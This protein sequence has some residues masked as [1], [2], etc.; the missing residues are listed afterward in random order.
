[1]VSKV[2]YPYLL[3]AIVLVAL[4]GPGTAGAQEIGNAAEIRFDGGGFMSEAGRPVVVVV[5]VS[6]PDGCITPGSYTWEL[7]EMN[8]HHIMAID[9]VLSDGPC[10]D[11]DPVT[12]LQLYEFPVK[13][14]GSLWRP[15]ELNY[16]EIWTVRGDEYVMHDWAEYAIVHIPE[17]MRHTLHL[18]AIVSR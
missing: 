11:E 15:G 18:P 13:P 12:L 10:A 7:Y 8:D 1:M 16:V 6:W 5:S 3:I 9:I 17:W 4:L 14:D 2:S